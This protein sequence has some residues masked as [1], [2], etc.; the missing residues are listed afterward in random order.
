MG[1]GLIQL[2]TIGIQDSPIIQNPEI[3]FFKTVY[4]QHTMFSL[5][6]NNRHIGN[7]NFGKNGH[8]IL[9]KNGDLLYNQCLKLE[10]PYF[11]I[12][13]TYN[14]KKVILSD[15]NINEL[16]ITYMNKNCIVLNI[17]NAGSINNWYIIPEKLFM[18]GNFKSILTKIE[19]TLVEPVLLPDYINLSNLRY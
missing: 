16:S 19:A 14:N 18:L 3:T 6:Q 7:L 11:E 1:G 17:N 9:E 4:R 8:K 13:K 2:I 10:I 5:C 12:I 15:Y